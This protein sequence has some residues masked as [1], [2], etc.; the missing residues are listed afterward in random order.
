[1]LTEQWRG[2]WVEQTS[3]F[4]KDRSHDTF[5]TIVQGTQDAVISAGNALTVTGQTVT[6]SGA[7]SA[8]TIKVNTDKLLNLGV[9]DV[10]G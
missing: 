3:W 1:M 6:N 8:N 7:L 2:Q 4:S 10:L 5:G 9:V